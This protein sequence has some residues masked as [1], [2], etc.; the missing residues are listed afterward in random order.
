[1]RFRVIFQSFIK[2]EPEDAASDMDDMDA[3]DPTQF[4]AQNDDFGGSND[5]EGPQILT[6][7]G[8]T[9]NNN[10]SDVTRVGSIQFSIGFCT[11]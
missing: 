10:V 2:E 6:S 7:L 1:M 4:L 3:V 11:L 5:D 8:L 9:Q